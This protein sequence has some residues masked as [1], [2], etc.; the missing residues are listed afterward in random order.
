MN[1][2]SIE[3]KDL[4]KTYKLYASS[5]KRLK[6][7]L[8]PFGKKYHSDFIAL[9]N[10]SLNIK[11][12]ETFAFIGKNGAGKS[13]LLK[14]LSGIIT[15]THGEVKTVGKV[16]ALLELGAGFNPEMT[17][18]ENVFLFGAFHGFSSDQMAKRY[19]EIVKFAEIGDF[20]HQPVRT[21]SSGMFVRLAFACSVHLEPDIL[22]VD[23]ALSVGD[24]RFQQKCFKFIEGLKENGTTIVLVSHDISLIKMVAD[25]A[26][27]I[28]HGKVLMIGTPKDV[29]N[30]YFDLDVATQASGVKVENLKDNKL[31]KIDAKTLKIHP[32]TLSFGVGVGKI[33]AIDLGTTGTFPFA[34]GMDELS[35]TVHAE[36]DKDKVN[37]TKMSHLYDDNM[38]LGVSLADKYGNYIF[39]MTTI[40]KNKFIPISVGKA[41]VTFK[42]TLPQLKSDDYLVNASMALGTQ[43]H[44]TQ[45]S[46]Y[47]AVYILEFRSNLKNVYGWM[48]QNYD[49][50][51]G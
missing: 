23:E 6:E 22:I 17:G 3:I 11:R 43:D 5:S 42:V 51:E 27:L 41:S 39:G 1:E 15:P 10:V 34:E 47:E 12:A 45:I 32:G 36:W 16:F 4:N 28:D 2:Y 7:A 40:D 48:Y 38:I 18:E 46:W 19:E 44:H 50:I 9:Q 33:V 37:E 13:T 20:I 29:A 8:N 21:Y 30:K 31:S 26:C 25:R 14:I 35:F 49:V 24:A